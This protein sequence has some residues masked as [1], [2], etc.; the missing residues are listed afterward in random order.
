MLAMG[1]KNY[2]LDR[3]VAITSIDNDRSI[4]VLEKLGMRF[5]RMIRFAEDGSEVR[6]FGPGT[7]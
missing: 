4:R 2:G 3:I 6:L 7:A 1:K 5:E